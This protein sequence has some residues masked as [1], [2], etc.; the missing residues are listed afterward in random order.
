ML[1]KYEAGKKWK[2]KTAKCSCVQ[3]IFIVAPAF[4]SA[5]EMRVHLQTVIG[6]IS[7]NFMI[8]QLHTCALARVNVA[9]ATDFLLVLCS[10]ILH[11]IAAMSFY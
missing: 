5:G 2:T 1:R 10:F 9:M 6:L 4:A 3:V 8:K 11:F 7:F